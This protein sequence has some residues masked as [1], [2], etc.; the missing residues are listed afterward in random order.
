MRFKNTTLQK[1]AIKV[2]HEIIN[3]SLMDVFIGLNWLKSAVLQDCW[4]L[5]LLR[6][7]YPS[8]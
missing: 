1:D 3:Q 5:D 4:A 6:A 7:I 2:A 8:G